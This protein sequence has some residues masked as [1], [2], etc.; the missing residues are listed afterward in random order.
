MDQNIYLGVLKKLKRAGTAR[1]LTLMLQNEPLL[2]ASLA[3]RVRQ[4]REVL[5][6]GVFIRTVSNGTLLFRSRIDEL[7]QAGIDDIEVS[8]DAFRKRTY[9]LVTHLAVTFRF[10][11]CPGSISERI[12]HVLWFK[13]WGFIQFSL[14]GFLL[15]APLALDFPLIMVILT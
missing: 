12:D 4:A 11:T 15:H 3:K 1:T 7:F 9:R 8:I 10:P 14:R 5:G 2:D 6:D 13:A